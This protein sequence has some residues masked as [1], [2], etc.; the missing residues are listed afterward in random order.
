MLKIIILIL[1]LQVIRYWHVNS[2]LEN[3]A[4]KTIS[5]LLFVS[6]GFSIKNTIKTI[7]LR[8]VRTL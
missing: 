4:A 8:T 6:M 7:Q 5:V 1:C 2:F 3:S